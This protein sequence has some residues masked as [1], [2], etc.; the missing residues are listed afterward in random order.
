MPGGTVLDNEEKENLATSGQGYL[1]KVG[2]L[3]RCGTPTDSDAA[4]LRRSRVSACP[5]AFATNGTLCTPPG[6]RD[7]TPCRVGHRPSDSSASMICYACYQRG[8]FMPACTFP[9]R[10]GQ[11][12]ID[13]YEAVTAEEKTRVLSASYEEV[14]FIKIYLTQVPASSKVDVVP[15]NGV[16]SVTPEVEPS[17]VGTDPASK[18]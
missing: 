2:L 18:N 3:P 7:T 13:D 10:N 11:I 1:G 5:F 9:V 16:P 12:I 6:S 8:H 14:K 15:P 17:L 4:L